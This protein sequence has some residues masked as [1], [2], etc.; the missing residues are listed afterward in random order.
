MAAM[1]MKKPLCE[2]KQ[3]SNKTGA[4]SYPR[5]RTVDT[6]GPVA[7]GG[8][9]WNNFLLLTHWLWLNQRSFSLIHFLCRLSLSLSPSPPPTQFDWSD[10][11]IAWH[12][13]VNKSPQV[14]PCF[15][16]FGQ[17]DN[18]K[19]KLLSESLAADTNNEILILIL[20]SMNKS[21]CL[22]MHLELEI[23]L[24]E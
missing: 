14:V 22:Y 24:T 2:Q 9:F 1:E 15:V 3:N 12:Q 7:L 11:Y 6:T 20:F 16:F 5:K 21:Y 23:I 10:L 17:T 4:T 19:Q 13:V 8:G 18:M